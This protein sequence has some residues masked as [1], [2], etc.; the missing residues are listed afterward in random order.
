M[1]GSSRARSLVFQ[2][3]LAVALVALLA[4]VAAHANPINI[5]NTDGTAG[6]VGTNQAFSLA[7]SA[8]S[9]I[10]M[11]NQVAGATLSFTTGALMPGSNLAGLH[12]GTAAEWSSA[13]STFEVTGTWNGF[14][15]V[16]F[17]G[18]FSGTITWTFNGCTGSIC[19]YTLSGPVTGTWIT[20][21]QVNGQT[22]QID[23]QFTG[24]PTCPGC[25]N[26]HGGAITDTGGVTTILTPEPGSLAL[27]GTGLLGM[28]FAGRKSRK[29]RRDLGRRGLKS[30]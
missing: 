6:T 12:V 26:Y 16:I 15:G 7:G 21:L 4:P 28:G 3:V 5:F 20:G 22:T 2:H 1:S 27:L 17:Q 18:S 14:T 10:G 29:V 11:F 25:G 19:G 9:S 23:F 8:V 30:M 24:T 13:G